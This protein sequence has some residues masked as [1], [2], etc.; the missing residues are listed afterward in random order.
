M[1]RERERERSHYNA[2]TSR[3][4]GLP[5]NQMSS[6]DEATRLRPCFGSTT[7]KTADR[8]VTSLPRNVVRRLIVAFGAASGVERRRQAGQ[9]SR[10]CDVV[11]SESGEA[12]IWTEVRLSSLK[13]VEVTN[14]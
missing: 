14:L 8:V 5:S 3:S 2:A 1:G 9:G 12:R 7:N 6:N 4:L 11:I 13:R 10:R